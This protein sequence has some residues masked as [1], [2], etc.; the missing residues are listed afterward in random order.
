M[1]ARLGASRITREAPPV[2]AAVRRAV[3]PN[4]TSKTIKWP[5]GVVSCQEAASGF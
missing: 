3:K 1:A 2:Y 4:C 5:Y